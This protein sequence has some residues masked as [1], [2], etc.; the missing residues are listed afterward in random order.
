MPIF[1][2]LANS[3]IMWYIE[4]AEINYGSRRHGFF[5]R[6]FW[7]IPGLLAQQCPDGVS[8]AEQSPGISLSLEV[9]E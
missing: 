6:Q 3:R 4:F 1:C 2:N 8:Y 7:N 5:Y 9:K